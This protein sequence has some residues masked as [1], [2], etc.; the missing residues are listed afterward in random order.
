MK[1]WID[2]QGGMHYHKAD[3]KVVQTTN[4]IHFKY[5]EV[6]RTVRRLGMRYHKE[7]AT[8]TIEGR[9][10]RPCPFCF[11]YDKRRQ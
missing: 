5:D 4:P 11:G 9:R 7:Y 2:K 3:C 6:E 8:I 1:I 10:Y